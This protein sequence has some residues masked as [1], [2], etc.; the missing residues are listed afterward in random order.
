MTCRV[1]G[2][3]Q[4]RGMVAA[5]GRAD[6]VYHALGLVQGLKEGSQLSQEGEVPLHAAQQPAHRGR[7]LCQ[8]RSCGSRVRLTC[9]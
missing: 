8:D 1:S 7:A 6:D 4:L 3:P 5:R 9:N 2:A